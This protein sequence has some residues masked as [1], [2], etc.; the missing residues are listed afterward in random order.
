MMIMAALW[1]NPIIIGGIIAAIPATVIA[2]SG[3]LLTR[4]RDAAA[5][6]SGEASGQAIWIGQVQED[7]R[8]ARAAAKEARE[9]AKAA[10]EEA[11]AAREEVRE[12]RAQLELCTTRIDAIEGINVDLQAENRELKRENEVLHTESRAK[13]TK[14]A[15]LQAEIDV[16]RT[17]IDELEKANGK[18]TD[19][20]DL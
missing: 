2:I 12:L 15:D 11:K 8:E 5:K 19:G 20:G 17:R 3:W 1:G 4:E 7:N 13:D 18:A 16:L 6:E 9:E 10:R 14:I